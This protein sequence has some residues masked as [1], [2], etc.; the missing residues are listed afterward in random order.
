MTSRKYIGLMALLLLLVCPVLAQQKVQVV[1]KTIKQD[2]KTLLDSGIVVQGKKASVEVTGW[3][4]DYIQVQ[5]DL[6]AKHPQ[7][8][9]AEKELRYIQYAITK[10]KDHYVLKNLF[11]AD[12]GSTKVRSNLS[13]VYKIFV[14]AD[15]RVVIRNDYGSMDLRNLYGNLDIE[16]K[17][18]EVSLDRFFGRMTAYLDYCELEGTNVDGLLR[19]DTRKTDISLDAFAG[20]VRIKNYL[21]KLDLSPSSM[22]RSLDVKSRNGKVSL[23]VNSLDAF[24]Y[25]VL[26]NSSFIS[27]PEGKSG[28]VEV[29]E[30][31]KESAFRLRNDVGKANITITNQLDPVTINYASKTGND[32]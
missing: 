8:K 26:V 29:D 10:T 32:E 18:S 14:P 5:M 23:T 7:R 22:L 11:Y 16:S 21:G 31:L 28:L 9:V 24:N 1:T 17:F 19:F 6:I 25:D 3:N 12:K 30:L 4:K 13:V 15:Q 2:L 20:D 27:L